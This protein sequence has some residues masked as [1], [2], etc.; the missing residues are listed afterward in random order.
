MNKIGKVSS[1][2]TETLKVSDLHALG[3]FSLDRL[4]EDG[5]LKDVPIIGTISGIAKTALNIQD[6]LFQKK[7]IY[8]LTGLS[9]TDP[10]KR[11]RLITKIEKDEEHEIKVGEKLLYII[12][13][14]DDHKSAQYI[15][16]LFRAFLNEEFNYSEFLRGATII[17]NIFIEDLKFFLEKNKE[18]FEKEIRPTESVPDTFDDLVNAGLCAKV[19]DQVSVEDETDPDMNQ[20]YRVEGGNAYYYLTDIGKKIKQVLNEPI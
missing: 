6:R 12:D 10:K 15:S 17:Q 4:L 20:R 19:T 1:S 2:L 5:V 3:E 8:F 9:N 14:C 13:K 16:K 11:N 18:Y 7:L